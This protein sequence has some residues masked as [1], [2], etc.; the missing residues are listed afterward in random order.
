M[1]VQR[2]FRVCLSLVLSFVLF[3]G[4][5][6]SVAQVAGESQPRVFLLDA[7]LLAS[8]HAAPESDTRKQELVKVV[9]AAADKAMH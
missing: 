4:L 2:G 9:R 5:Q 3:A 6:Q 1:L 7:K 8:I